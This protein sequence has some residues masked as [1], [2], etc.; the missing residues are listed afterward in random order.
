MYKSGFTIIE[1]MLG[2]LLGSIITTVLFT[3]FFQINR[4]A[5]YGDQLIDTDMKIMILHHQLERDLNGMFIPQEAI[6]DDEQDEQQEK[7]SKETTKQPDTAKKKKKRKLLEKPFYSINKNN[8]LSLLTFIS[9]NPVRIYEKPQTN[10]TEPKKPGVPYVVRVVYRVLPDEQ[11]KGAFKITRQ[12]SEQLDFKNFEP[13][14]KRVRPYVIADNIKSITMN[15]LR[16]IDEEK[17]EKRT[18]KKQ[19]QNEQKKKQ[20]KEKPINYASFKQWPPE[21]DAIELPHIVTCKLTL[22]TAGQE[23]ERSLAFQVPY[24][25]ISQLYPQEEEEEPEP[26]QQPEKKEPKQPDKK[27]APGKQEQQKTEFKVSDQLKKQLN[28][29][30]LPGAP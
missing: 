14:S 12:E 27:P 21:Q 1:L 25:A 2:L 23:N 9:N 13:T 10:A 26:E 5:E 8:N 6:P 16:P 29:L 19:P 7:E 4:S 20:E 17:Q 15:F 22:Y 3:A 11:N 28:S 24:L 30:K 18:E